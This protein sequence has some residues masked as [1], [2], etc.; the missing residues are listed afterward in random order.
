MRSERFEF[1]NPE[2]QS[3]AARLDR[4]DGA[5][6]GVALFAHCFTCGK[7]V[8][9]A[10]RIAAGLAA[11]GIAT[12]RFDFTGLGSSDGDFA[13]TGFSSNIADLLAAAAHLRTRLA[14]PGLLIGHSLGGAA[15]LA[16]AAAVPEARAVAVIGAPY[17]PAHVLHLIAPHL[18]EIAETGAARVSLGGRD[19]TIRQ[20]FVTDLTRRAPQETIAHLGKALLVLHSPSDATVGIDN[21]RQIFEAAR[22]PKSFIALDGAAHLLDNRH[23]A[24]FAAAIIAV[25]AARYIGADTVAAPPAR[26]PGEGVV[27]EETGQGALQNR[28]IAGP[29]LLLADEPAAAGGNETGPSPY[30]LLLAALGACTSI[31]LRLYAARKSLALRQVRVRL[32]HRRIHAEDCA[33]CE[34]EAGLLDEIEREVTLAGDLDAG[35]RARLMEIADRCP[36]HRTLSGEIKIRTRL[37]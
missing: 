32:H 1:P 18:D 11:E 2:G 31:T 21:A 28:I 35:Q 23:D 12:L 34:T 13:N 25:W 15:V 14:A 27:V 17:D 9:A 19:F 24:A 6:K 30:D 22:H 8:V 36:V 7:D 4:P 26:D 5:I 37:V 33:D 20:D 3:L 10:S 29:H 16:A